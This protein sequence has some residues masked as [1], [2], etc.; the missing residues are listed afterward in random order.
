MRVNPTVCTSYLFHDVDKIFLLMFKKFPFIC[1]CKTFP[2][3][4]F[5]PLQPLPPFLPP[6][7]VEM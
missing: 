6:S 7:L 3:M 5:F 1:F 2:L 4:D